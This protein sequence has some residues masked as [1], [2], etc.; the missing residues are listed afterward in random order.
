MIG[1][2]L[3]TEVKLHWATLITSTGRGD[4]FSALLM[5]DGSAAQSSRPK[6]LSA[7]FSDSFDIPDLEFSNIV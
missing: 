7:L 2:C 1:S 4:C 3:C 5:S 6:P